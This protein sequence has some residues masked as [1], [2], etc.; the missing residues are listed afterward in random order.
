MER[1]PSPA[2]PT[3][4]FGATNEQQQKTDTCQDKQTEAVESLPKVEE[5][6]KPP[7]P[8]IQAVI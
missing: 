5:Q 4:P 2:A 3:N 7:A 1:A 6:Q 8:Q